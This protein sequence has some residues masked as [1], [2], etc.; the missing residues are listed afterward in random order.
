MFC[1]VERWGASSRRSLVQ[2]QHLSL[3]SSDSYRI[4]RV[5][6]EGMSRGIRS[7]E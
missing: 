3:E 2:V 6:P 7:F 4:P 1:A 5:A